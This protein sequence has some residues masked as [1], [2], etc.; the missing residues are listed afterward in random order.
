MG[1]PKRGNSN[2]GMFNHPHTVRRHK[3]RERKKAK[4]ELSDFYDVKEWEVIAFGKDEEPYAPT[5]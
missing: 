5:I 3:R 4:H 1:E 2:F